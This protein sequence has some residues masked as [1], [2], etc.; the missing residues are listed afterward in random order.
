MS[1]TIWP[2]ATSNETLSSAT[3]PPKRTVR[4]RTDRMGCSNTDMCSRLYGQRRALSTPGAAVGLALL[5][6]RRLV[7][8]GRTGPEHYA[9]PGGAT[10]E[11]EADVSPTGSRVV[12]DRSLGRERG[13]L[14]G[15]AS[16]RAHSVR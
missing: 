8:L 16:C 7:I 3:M 9:E 14:P 4:S 1:P 5:I 15:E 2:P 6:R 12:G 13:R 11:E 10:H